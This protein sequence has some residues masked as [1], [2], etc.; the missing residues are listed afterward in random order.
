MGFPLYIVLGYMTLI[1]I[2]FLLYL[3]SLKMK[4]K[5]MVKVVKFV[6]Y[7]L[8]WN[9]LIRMYMEIYFGMAL[10]SV[11]NMHTVDWESPFE[12]VQVSNSAGLVGLIL[13]AALP[14][15]VFVPIYFRKRALW[16]DEEFK[17]TYGALLEGTR[18]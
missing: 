10:A 6:R 15:A 7:Y 1:V 3:V 11:L 2:Y 4:C 9:G 8:F 13:I 12:W 14:I 5:C 17:K 16:S 18:I